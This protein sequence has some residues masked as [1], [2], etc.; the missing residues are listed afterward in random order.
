MTLK[1]VAGLLAGLAATAAVAQVPQ[2]GLGP[3][4]R[5]ATQTRAQVLQRVQGMFARLDLNRDGVLTQQEAQAAGQ[6]VRGQRGQRAMNPALR[7]QRLAQAFARRDLNNDGVITRAE[8]D[9][10][11]AQHADRRQAGRRGQRM[12]GVAVSRMFATADFNR[13]GRVTVQEATGA[14][15]Q[16]F[17][18][19]DRNRDGVLTNAER[20]QARG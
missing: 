5:N 17:D 19:A 4:Q 20:Q 15:L 10:V 8:F 11:R 9:Q 14:A 2:G 18:A 3:G 7:Q 1:L 16:R 13:D 6:Q 12:G